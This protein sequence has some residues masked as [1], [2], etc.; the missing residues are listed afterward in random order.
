MIAVQWAQRFAPIGM[1]LKHSGH[2]F[3]VGDFGLT[4]DRNLFSG[5]TTKK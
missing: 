4:L 1:S 5:N 3:V 2:F